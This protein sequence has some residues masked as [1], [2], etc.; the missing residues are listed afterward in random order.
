LVNYFQ[1]DDLHQNPGPVNS[2]GS[3][4]TDYGFS[5]RASP[6]LGLQARDLIRPE[7][8][9]RE[10]SYAVGDAATEAVRAVAP[11]V[12]AL[13]D[14]TVEICRGILRVSCEGRRE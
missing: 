13:P 8:S 2:E 6:A 5:L 9:L 4:R 7:L 12:I 3:R 1:H 14:H 11:A 10:L